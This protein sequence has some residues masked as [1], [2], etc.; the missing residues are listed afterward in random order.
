[1]ALLDSVSALHKT[2]ES[3][4]SVGLS[5][6]SVYTDLVFGSPGSIQ[7]AWGQVTVSLHGRCVWV[8][9]AFTG[10]VGNSH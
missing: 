5:P 7:G 10:N 3:T 1:M 2:W 8:N 6:W 9:R 4:G